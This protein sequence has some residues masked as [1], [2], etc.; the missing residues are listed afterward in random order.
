MLTMQH[1]HTFRQHEKLQ[2]AK[3]KA[4]S[5]V[6]DAIVEMSVTGRVIKDLD[7]IFRK[8]ADWD[9][10]VDHILVLQVPLLAFPASC[11]QQRCRDK[12]CAFLPKDSV[13]IDFVISGIVG[14]D[15]TGHLLQTR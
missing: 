5:S 15:C 11:L 6:F 12:F 10:G 1:I 4:L 13:V 3:D 7:S 8:G 9:L 2:Q 14:F